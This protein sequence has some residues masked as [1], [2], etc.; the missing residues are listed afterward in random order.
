MSAPLIAIN[1]SRILPGGT[2]NQE[3]DFWELDD[4][5]IEESVGLFDSCLSVMGL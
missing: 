1:R 5:P 3:V 4:P 2:S